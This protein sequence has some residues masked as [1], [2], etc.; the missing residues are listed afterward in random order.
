MAAP[1]GLAAPAVSAGLAGSDAVLA[2]LR[3]REERRDA[4]VALLRAH[5][6]PVLSVTIVTPGPVKDDAIARSACAAAEAAVLGACRERGWA[7]SGWRRAGGGPGPEFQVA[8]TA[9]AGELKTAMVALEE[10]SGWGRLWDLDVVSGPGP[11]GEPIGW[12]RATLG[13]PSRRC[14][15][16]DADAAGCGR[17][18]RHHPL[19]VDAARA[20][21]AAHASGAAEHR[22]DAPH[23][24]AADLGSGGTAGAGAGGVRGRAAW[25]SGLAVGALLA[26]ARLTPKPGLVDAATT[27]AHD[28]MDLALLERSAEALRPWLAACWQVGYARGEVSGLVALGIAGEAA[29][30]AATGGVNTHK[31]ALFALGLLLAGLGAEDAASGGAYG[32]GTADAGG[33]GGTSTRVRARAA[34]LAAPLLAGWRRRPDDSHGASALRDLGVTGARGEAAA[35]F[36]TATAGL[37]AYRERLAEHG[38]PDDAWRWAL[39]ALIAANPD[40]NLVARGGAEGLAHARAWASG[41][42]GRRPGG[43]ALIAELSAADVDFTARRLSPGGSADLLAVAWLLDALDAEAGRDL[44]ET[45]GSR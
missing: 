3:R 24:S 7:V 43:M 41:V 11:D 14:L 10:A 26:E 15:V 17:S 32:T 5:G 22:P 39:V 37:R 35:G 19:L 33:G 38:D 12:G 40:T 4:Q 8:V 44:G 42:L 16:C 27:G 29:M 45:A 9:P 31:G 20:A 6:A 1:A 18:R 2:V 30:R 25:A 34:L 13:L 36:A 23:Y 28:D 21:L